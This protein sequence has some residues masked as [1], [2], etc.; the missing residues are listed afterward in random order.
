[1]IATHPVDFSQLNFGAFSSDLA[2]MNNF[3]N[4]GGYGQFYPEV[5]DGSVL[6]FYVPPYDE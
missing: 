5:P 4:A 3:F 6:G 2:D 1:M